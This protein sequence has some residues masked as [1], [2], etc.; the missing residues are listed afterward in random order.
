MIDL[1]HTAL[2]IFR[3]TLAAIDIPATM[4]RKLDRNGSRIVVN[5]EPFELAPSV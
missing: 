1:K 4:R 3:E 2:K 5:R